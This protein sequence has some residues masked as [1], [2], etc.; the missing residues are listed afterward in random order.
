MEALRITLHWTAERLRIS[1]LH[2]I[3]LL[4]YQYAD[5]MSELHAELHNILWDLESVCKTH[6]FGA[7]FGATEERSMDLIGDLMI[8]MNRW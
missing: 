1:E 6:R 4:Q 2:L 5:C 8:T 7:P 3:Q